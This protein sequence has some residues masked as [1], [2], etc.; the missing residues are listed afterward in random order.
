MERFAARRPPLSKVSVN[1]LPFESF[2]RLQN[3]SEEEFDAFVDWLFAR[4]LSELRT[5]RGDMA[6]TRSAWIGYFQ[7]G[8]RAELFLDE[9]MQHLPDLF[10]RAQYPEPEAKEV[11]AM[12]KNLS[13]ADFGI[14]KP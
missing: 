6:K 2:N 9:L 4:T 11:L 7:R 1:Q 8:L 10:R 14:Q 3:A 13:L 5:S 12:I